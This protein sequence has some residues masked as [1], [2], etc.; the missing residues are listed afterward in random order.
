MLY[1]TFSVQLLLEVHDNFNES[2]EIMFFFKLGF[3]LKTQQYYLC[4]MRNHS[5]LALMCAPARA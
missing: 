3:K 2:L 1:L 5:H 4:T